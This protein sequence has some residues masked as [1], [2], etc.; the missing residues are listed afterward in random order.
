MLRPL[1]FAV[2]QEFDR[3]L[4][5]HMS[6]PLDGKDGNLSAN[7]ET[8]WQIQYALKDLRR[9]LRSRGDQRLWDY[10]PC[11]DPTSGRHTMA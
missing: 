1:V 7:L 10:I 3:K 5:L 2:L 11:K 6:H 9:Y 4:F 8:L